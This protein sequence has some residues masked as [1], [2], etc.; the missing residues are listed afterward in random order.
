[1]KETTNSLFSLLTDIQDSR[2][3]KLLSHAH[4]SFLIHPQSH[5]GPVLGWTC[6]TRTLER[7]TSAPWEGMVGRGDE[8]GDM[9]MA[10][11]AVATFL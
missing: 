11:E 8:S 6:L 9:V 1:M 3:W 10:D 7:L 4:Y 2:E 5:L